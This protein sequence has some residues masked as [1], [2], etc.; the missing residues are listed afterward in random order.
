MM[1]DRGRMKLSSYSRWFAYKSPP[2]WTEQ[3][4]QDKTRIG[5]ECWSSDGQVDE[6]HDK[7]IITWQ[8]HDDWWRVLTLREDQE[9]SCQ[10]KWSWWRHEFES[11]IW[12]GNVLG[13][14]APHRT[15]HGSEDEGWEWASCISARRFSC[16]KA[17]K[18]P[19]NSKEKKLVNNTAK[20]KRLLI[21][22]ENNSLG[23]WRVISVERM[24]FVLTSIFRAMQFLDCVQFWHDTTW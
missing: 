15:K 7:T 10:V 12:K 14:P 20:L 1:P 9:K 24:F 6:L 17:L 16:N 3:T 2:S 5:N 11:M 19:N 21:L 23:Q 22:Y 13:T 4:K 8:W 18:L